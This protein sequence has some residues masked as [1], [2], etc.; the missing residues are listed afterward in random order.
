MVPLDLEEGG[1]SWAEVL[2]WCWRCGRRWS[3]VS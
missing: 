2:L 3:R 1:V